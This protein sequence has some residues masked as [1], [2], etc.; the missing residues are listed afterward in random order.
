[1]KCQSELHLIEDVYLLLVV[2]GQTPLLRQRPGVITLA[3]SRRPGGWRERSW[4]QGCGGILHWARALGAGLSSSLPWAP[5]R[6][7][8]LGLG[9][10]LESGLSRV[11]LPFS[12]SMCFGTS[13]RPSWLTRVVP[14][15]G[16]RPLHPAPLPQLSHSSLNMC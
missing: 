4:I 3:S 7:Q 10:S 11:L 9:R 5:E 8:W 1:M 15:A 2:R 6:D 12:V 13:C 16:P 14:M